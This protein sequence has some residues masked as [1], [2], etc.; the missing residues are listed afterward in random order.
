MFAALKNKTLGLQII[1]IATI[2]AAIFLGTTLSLVVLRVRSVL[3]DIIVEKSQVELQL[4]TTKLSK[5]AQN[6]REDVTILSRVPELTEFLE[7]SYK[8]TSTEASEGEESYIKNLFVAEEEVKKIYDQ[9]RLINT[10]GM[11]LI[12]VDFDNDGGS[13]V[14]PD[15][16]LQDKSNRDYVIETNALSPGSMYTSPISLNREGANQDIERPY[17]PV[18][19]YAVPLF[20]S[21]GARVGMIVANVKFEDVLASI[22]LQD[23]DVTPYAVDN[24]GF[25]ALHPDSTKL[26]GSAIDLDTGA[27]ITRDIEN[28]DVQALTQDE[29]IQIIDNTVVLSSRVALGSG[30]TP[31][32]LIIIRQQSLYSLFA[33][34]RSFIVYAGSVGA[35]VFI[36]L[37]FVFVF[38]VSKVLSPIKRVAEAAR[39]IGKGDF[40]TQIPKGF[41]G[42]LAELVQAFEEMRVR[43][44]KQYSHFE[45]SVVKKNTELESKLEELKKTRT[46]MTNLLEDIDEEKKN[47]IAASNELKKFE[48]AMASTS[49]IVIIAD[50]KRQ[51]VY[52]NPATERIT[53][54]TPKEVHGKNVDELWGKSV[55]KEL[56]KKV[57]NTVRIKKESFTGILPCVKKNGDHIDASISFSPVLDKKRN[58]Q[59]VVYTARD[60]SEERAVDKAKTEFVSLASH[61]LRTPLST[62]NWYVE[63]L[64]DGDAGKLTDEQRV[65]LNEIHEGNQRMIDLVNALLNVSRLELGTFAVE[66]KKTDMKKLFESVVKEQLPQIKE[67]KLKFTKKVSRAIP[68]MNVDPKL[69]W[70][71]LQN[72]LSNAV[73]YTKQSGKVMV[74]LDVV[75]AGKKCMGKTVK[76]DMLCYS[77][78]DTGCGIPK[79]QQDKIF[80]KLFRADNVRTMDVSGTG[81]GLYIVKAIIEETGGCV[82]FTSKAG[83]GSTF[84]ATIPLSGM[85]KKQGTKNLNA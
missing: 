40:D 28:F 46:A 21:D 35:L 29:Y 5:V 11:E 84:F 57:W 54:F 66:P 75:K 33:P 25:Y 8:N 71:V 27:N 38:A 85:K 67:K 59:Y 82:G 83:K 3:S 72:Y 20:G 26:W 44:Q 34:I 65:H 80:T 12:R 52:A 10:E 4:A 73:K 78:S 48:L 49:D 18:V 51:I 76:E 32:H 7:F 60:I 22:V 53:G 41:T 9:L 69:A 14:V 6:I 31:S 58:I 61:Q 13:I 24:Q 47:A 63:M 42:E 19:R 56:Y 45:S 62:I 79:N 17:V 23:I 36:V 77:V 55:P 64:L 15:S 74:S 70:I 1:F 16:R 68:Q 43:V 81:L 2:L 39:K 50:N 37:F 30:I